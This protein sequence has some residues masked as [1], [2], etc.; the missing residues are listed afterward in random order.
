LTARSLALALL[1]MFGWL[2][3]GFVAAATLL[4]RRDLV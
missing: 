2:G 4:R 1:V 3:S